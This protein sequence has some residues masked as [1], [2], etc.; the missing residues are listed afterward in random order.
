MTP[1][2]R[3]DL[4][5]GALHM[6]LR[7][8]KIVESALSVFIA[9]LRDASQIR[10][11]LSLAHLGQISISPRNDKFTLSSILRKISSEQSTI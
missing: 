11:A 2:T 6:Y 3:Y 5:N 8:R 1:G 7:E 10:P 4:A 9:H